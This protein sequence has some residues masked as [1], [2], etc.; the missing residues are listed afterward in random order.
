MFPRA[1]FMMTSVGWVAAGRREALQ[2]EEQTP[3][4]YTYSIYNNGQHMIWVCNITPRTRIQIKGVRDDAGSS[5]YNWR[6]E[7][8]SGSK[9]QWEAVWALVKASTAD[10][11]TMITPVANFQKKKETS[12]L[13]HENPAQEGGEGPSLGFLGQSSVA[14]SNLEPIRSEL[15]GIPIWAADQIARLEPVTRDCA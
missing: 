7:T 10:E 1:A 14:S 12:Q 15:P 5:L 2:L 4:I 6:G 3:I 13:R 11:F 8:S 9:R